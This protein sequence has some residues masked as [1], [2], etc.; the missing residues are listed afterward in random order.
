LKHPQQMRRQRLQRPQTALRKL[1][2]QQKRHPSKQSLSP[3]QGPQR[4]PPIQPADVD[5][6]TT[7]IIK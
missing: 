5:R 1:Q 6:A 4:R 7:L 2:R 3:L